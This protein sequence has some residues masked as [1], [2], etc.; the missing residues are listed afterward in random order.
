MKKERDAKTIEAEMR[1][2]QESLRRAKD[3]IRTLNAELTTAKKREK[4]RRYGAIG[5]AIEESL[6]VGELSTE[7]LKELIACLKRP[8]RLKDGSETTTAMRPTSA[9]RL[10]GLACVRIS[11]SGERSEPD[12]NLESARQQPCL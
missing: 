1:K 12:D 5:S 2:E 6:G 8:I 11:S 7:D 4:A 10:P 3:Q 9:R